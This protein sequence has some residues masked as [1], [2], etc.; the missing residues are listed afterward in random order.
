MKPSNILSIIF[1]SAALISCG[2]SSNDKKSDFS[3]KTNAPGNGISLHED[4]NL[5][6]K[7]PKNLQIDSIAYYINDARI[8]ENTNLSQQKLGKQNIKA[9]VYTGGEAQTITSPLLILNDEHPKVYTFE[10]LNTY[11]HDIT[12]YTQGLEFYN[13]TMYESTGQYKESKLRKVDYKSGDIIKNVNLS[14]EYFGEGLTVLHNKLYQLT[15]QKGTGFVYDA[16]TLEKQSSFKYNN[17]KEGWGL[18]NDGNVL[19]K[20]DGTE[21]IWI[22]DPETLEEKSFIQVYTNKGKI[23]RVNELEWINGKIYANI[24]QKDGVAIINPK[25][26]AVEGVIDFTPLKKKVTQ[27]QG[28]DVLNGMAFNTTT[29]SLFVTGKR[30]DKLFEVTVKPK[31]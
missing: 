21:K 17:S 25:N 26:G 1:L 16:N 22:L 13:D 18:C 4:L 9:I 29:K 11:P 8:S 23:G 3:L 27:H 5:S 19:Y 7:N 6:I 28:L 14:D 15:W 20:S 31:K 10:L 24:Y 30:W 2:S 12:S